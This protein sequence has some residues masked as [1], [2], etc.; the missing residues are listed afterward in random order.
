MAAAQAS[1]PV[2][3]PRASW[4]AWLRFG[5]AAALL[6]YLARSAAIDWSAFGGFARHPVLVMA[7]LATLAATVVLTA[8][9][10]PVLLRAAG[11]D[12]A[13]GPAIQLSLIGMFFGL[14]LPGSASGDAAKIYYAVSSQARGT[15]AELA[16]VVLFDRAVGMWAMFAMPFLAAP[17]FGTAVSSADVFQLLLWFCGGV[18]VLGAV[19]LGGVLFAPE[20]WLERGR[21]ALAWEL[22]WRIVRA[23]RE[24][25]TSL[26]SIA[27]AFVIS[28]AA[29]SAAITTTALVAGAVAPDSQRAE[30]ALVVPL[31]FIANALPIT[32]GGLGVGEL[33]FH[34][35]FQAVGLEGGAEVAVGWRLGVIAAALLGGLLYVRGF[36][37]TVRPASADAPDLARKPG[38]RDD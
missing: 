38:A 6:S 26:A 33:A 30:L 3:G 14:F 25:R 37:G 13:T 29:H 19:A 5:V 9:R 28:I 27:R 21:R 11:F 18:F 24:F 15:R 35:L 16:T 17:F 2:R 23:V 12:L 8:V 31:G 1:A 10:L 7:A 34:Q 32:P 20:A 22:P 36:R 4:S